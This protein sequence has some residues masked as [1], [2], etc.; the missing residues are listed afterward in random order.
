MKCFMISLT[1]IYKLASCK[2]F[3]MFVKEN[4]II[5]FFFSI[6]SMSWL[7]SKSCGYNSSKSND[8]FVLVRLEDEAAPE[9]VPPLWSRRQAE[10]FIARQTTWLQNNESAALPP[11]RLQDVIRQ[12]LQANPDHYEAVSSILNY[13]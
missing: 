10:L 11:P 13:F 2:D 1:P 5:Y 8:K 9:E 4:H 3:F 12:V 7:C 6:K